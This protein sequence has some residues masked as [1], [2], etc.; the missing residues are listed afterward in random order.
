MSHRCI[1]SRRELLKTIGALAA[2]GTL[3]RWFVEET[4]D[5][6]EPATPSSAL[7]ISQISR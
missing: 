7:M 2:I 1:R 3:P 5:A 6:A 4:L